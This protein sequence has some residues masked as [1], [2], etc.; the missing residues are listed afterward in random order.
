VNAKPPGWYRAAA[1]SDE[2]SA[3]D[4]VTTN[5]HAPGA[6]TERT[7]G[8]T[9]RIR[10]IVRRAAATACAQL[11]EFGYDVLD[12]REYGYDAWCFDVVDVIN[13]GRERDLPTF[14]PDSN[15]MWSMGPEALAARK[16]CRCR[17]W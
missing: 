16:C 7:P 5:G 15:A 11:V 17:T 4:P 14:R 9:A 10:S 8:Y 1:D 13:A 2:D 12:T 6:P 3:A